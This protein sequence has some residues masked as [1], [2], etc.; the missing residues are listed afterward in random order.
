MKEQ[1]R[2]ISPLLR[3]QPQANNTSRVGLETLTVFLGIRQRQSATP[4]LL[5]FDTACDARTPLTSQ[6]LRCGLKLNLSQ[7]SSFRRGSC[8]MGGDRALKALPFMHIYTESCDAMLLEA[9]P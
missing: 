8:R 2:P 7:L 5:G 6:R 4:A 3:P 1:N 9:T